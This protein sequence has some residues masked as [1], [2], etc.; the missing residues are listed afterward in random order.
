MHAH[1]VRV[2]PLGGGIMSNGKRIHDPIT[3][4]GSSPPNETVVAGGS[5]AIANRQIA[6]W[7]A[8]TQNPKDVIEHTPIITRGTPLELF[9]SNG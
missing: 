2:D 6:P 4:S 3:Y 1:D 7:C 5:W 9:G 8:G